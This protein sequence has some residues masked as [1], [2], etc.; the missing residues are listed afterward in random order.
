M[1]T[2]YSGTN[3]GMCGM[4]LR[5]WADARNGAGNSF[6]SNDARHGNPVWHFYHSG[7]G[8]YGIYR[9]FF[10]FDTSGV[11]IAPS[12]ATL[13][14]TGYSRA[15]GDLIVVKSEQGGTLAAGDFNSLPS[16]GLTALGNT[17]GNGTGTLAS[18]SNF[19]YSAEITTWS[20]S[21]YNDI[22]LNATAI[23][24]M[25]SLDTFKVCLM[26]HDNDYLDQD[27]TTQERNG[28]YFADNS[29]TSSDPYIDYTPGVAVTDN[30]ILFGT[31]F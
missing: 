15:E 23:A 13:K 30:A 18:V 22:T 21:G 28:C 26:N 24:D 11:T 29:G 7:R 16:A 25:V 6:D 14:I 12:A 5:S 20:T 9:A 3:D 10:E 1:A 31:N 19:T 27:G 8:T 17:D 4:G 2:I